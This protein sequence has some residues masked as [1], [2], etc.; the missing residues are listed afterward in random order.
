MHTS[1]TEKT[2]EKYRTEF[3]ERMLLELA[4]N[5]GLVPFYKDIRTAKLK[6][7]FEDSGNKKGSKL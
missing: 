6:K 7:L 4:G 3:K 5:F 1:R 2:R